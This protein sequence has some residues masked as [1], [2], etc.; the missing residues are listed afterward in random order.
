MKKMCL[1]PVCLFL[2]LGMAFGETA[3]QEEL[4]H[5]L[6]MPNSSSR[7]VNE[8]NAVLQLDNLANYLKDRNLHSGQIHILGYAADVTN[9]IDSFDLS[10]E[11]ALFVI[12]ELNKRGLPKDVF[13]DPVGYGAVNLW[14]SN[15]SEAA[16]SPNRR[17]RIMLDGELLVPEVFNPQEIE[18]EIMAFEEISAELIIDD[19]ENV[20]IVDDSKCKLKCGLLWKLL[21]PLLLL[22]LI[23]AFILLKRKKKPVQKIKP[24]PEIKHKK[25]IEPHVAPVPLGYKTVNLEEEIRFLAYMLSQLRHS[26]EGNPDEDWHIAA[27]EISAKYEADAYEVYYEDENWWAKKPLE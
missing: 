23:A 2:V 19:T 11:R 24:E 12:N 13:A 7:F 6:F 8:N 3:E 21:L 22:A 27:R 1:I 17:V 9:S 26:W 10:A 15:V 25:S 16:R 4:D 14:G 18:T 20:I 5:L